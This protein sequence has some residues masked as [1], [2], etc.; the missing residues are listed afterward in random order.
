MRPLCLFALSLC[1]LLPCLESSLQAGEG[2]VYSR[3][4]GGMRGG[5]T[6][7]GRHVGHRGHFGGFGFRPFQPTVAGSWY[8]RPY[9]YHFDYYRWRYS[10]PPQP[11]DC[12][13]A[14]GTVEA[15]QN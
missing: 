6:G 3:N 7:G 14:V 15:A 1:L 12:P 10:V 8:A 13:C 11:Q 9:P 4:R 2:P 5:Y